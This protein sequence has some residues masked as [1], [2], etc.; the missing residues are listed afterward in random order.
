MLKNLK[1]KIGVASIAFFLCTSLNYIHINWAEAASVPP[2]PNQTEKK[3]PPPK[4]TEHKPAV[5]PNVNRPKPTMHK[6]PTRPNV[7]KPK[8]PM[9]KPVTKP[10]ANR[11][12]PSVH[13]PPVKSNVN[14]PNRPNPPV[15]KSVSKVNVNKSG[16][17]NFKPPMTKPGQR[18]NMNVGKRPEHRTKNN[19]FKPPTTKPGQRPNMNVG[20]RPE[21]RAENNGFKP[22][23]TKP[24]QRP[25]MNVGKRPE[26]R[27]GNKGFKPPTTKPGQ[28]PNMNVGRKPEHR[29]GN[30]GFKPPMTKPGQ[31][32]NMNVGRR[33]GHKLENK[34]FQPPINKPKRDKLPRKSLKNFTVVSPKPVILSSREAPPPPPDYEYKEDKPSVW[35][36]VLTGIFLERMS[37]AKDNATLN[38]ELTDMGF[39]CAGLDLDYPEKYVQIYCNNYS[40]VSDNHVDY[41]LDKTSL[42]VSNYNPPYYTI[43]VNEFSADVSKPM[44]RKMNTWEFKYNIDARSVVFTNLYGDY[45]YKYKNSNYMDLNTT[46]PDIIA[47]AEMAFYMAYNMR[48][49][50]NQADSFYDVTT[51]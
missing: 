41:Y 1:K 16:N 10:N 45:H 19:G 2:P 38:S 6:P 12:K 13:R 7:N 17:N 47:M 37:F 40:N 39:E 31:K 35:E 42:K 5:K 11:P 34:G 27:T 50:D 46:E 36:R 43:K 23:T 48:F 21:H 8:P 18:P 26:H 20:K 30:K 22:P 29:T 3:Q 51:L 49:F 44:D 9:H 28:R 15:H 24:G 14:R 33:P 25:N 32:T 4:K